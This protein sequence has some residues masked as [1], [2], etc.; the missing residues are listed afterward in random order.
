MYVCMYVCMIFV[1]FLQE[2]E[3]MK[4]KTGAGQ[5]RTGYATLTSAMQRNVKWLTCNLFDRVV[6]Q[7][8]I[9][10]GV[11]DCAASGQDIL[12]GRHPR[13]G[14]TLGTGW[15]CT[16][17]DG[18]SPQYRSGTS[19]GSTFLLVLWINCRIP[20]HYAIPDL[21]LLYSFNLNAQA[22]FQCQTNG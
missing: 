6:S 15:F 5:K 8:P 12:V 10:H 1:Y 18:N 17:T 9:E 14:L 7:A 4:K 19:T 2:L 22:N 13:H 21:P 20:H 3:P 16:G 11:E